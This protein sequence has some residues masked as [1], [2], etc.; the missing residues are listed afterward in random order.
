MIS[1]TSAQLK[2]IMQG[3]A[4]D[5]KTFIAAALAGLGIANALSGK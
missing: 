3:F 2:A 4:E 5:I 1:N